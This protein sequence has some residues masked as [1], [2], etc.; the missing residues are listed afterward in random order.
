[1]SHSNLPQ[2]SRSP[3]PL[4]QTLAR[5]RKGIQFYRRGLFP[6]RPAARASH[7]T[8]NEVRRPAVSDLQSKHYIIS[9]STQDESP[10]DRESVH[11]AETHRLSRMVLQS[12]Q[13][14]DLSSVTEAGTCSTFG[15]SVTV[16]INSNAASF[17]SAGSD[18]WDR[19]SVTEVSSTTCDEQLH[20]VLEQPR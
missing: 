13:F 10:E 15:N 11:E 8:T 2:R 16:P 19:P 6:C 1:M 17:E 14:T 12:L 4:Q 5:I 7:E 9:S 18:H 3:S 20:V